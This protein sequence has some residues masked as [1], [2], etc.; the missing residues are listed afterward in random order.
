[1]NVLNRSRRA[2]EN[3]GLSIGQAARLLGLPCDQ[4]ARCE[5]SDAAYADLGPARLADLYEVNVEWLS[6]RS[7]L[8]DEAAIRRIRQLDKAEALTFCDRDRIAEILASLP[9]RAP[10]TR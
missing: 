2:R 3:A 10:S 8:R 4:I 7:E 1:M 9:R 5:I 6:G